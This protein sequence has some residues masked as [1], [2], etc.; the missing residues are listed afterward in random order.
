MDQD[1]VRIPG[2]DLFVAYGDPLLIRK[3][4]ED[5]LPSRKSDQKGLKIAAGAGE[6]PV[7]SAVIDQDLQGL[8]VLQG[9]SHGGYPLLLVPDKCFRRVLCAED[10][11]QVPDL[12]ILFLQ[13]GGRVDINIHAVAFRLL[14][15]A[16]RIADLPVDG[17]DEVR[18]A[19]EN[20]LSGGGAVVELRNPVDGFRIFRQRSSAVVD[21]G[22]ARHQVRKPQGGKKLRTVGPKGQ[23][24]FRPFGNGDLPAIVF[25]MNGVSGLGGAILRPGDRPFPCGGGPFHRG[26]GAAGRKGKGS[27]CCTYYNTDLSFH[28]ILQGLQALTPSGRNVMEVFPVSR[29]ISTELWTP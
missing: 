23:D 2:Q 27:H 22:T 13:G 18:S 5:V 26:T 1:Q 20:G 16:A 10:P 8:P 9:L 17:I 28:L 4:P 25:Q 7:V 3:I 15:I 11:P 21:Q 14:D 24:P 6:H 12:L 29:C 19:G